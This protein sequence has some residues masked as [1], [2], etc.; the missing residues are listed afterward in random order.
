MSRPV[1]YCAITNHGFGHAVRMASVASAVQKLNPDILLILV[2]TAP[3]WLLDSYIEGDFIYRPRAFDVGVIQGDSITMDLEAT[4]K[5][6]DD[7]R[8]REKQIV[9][10]EVE[11]CNLN[12]VSLILGDV[13]AM[14]TQIA[15][16]ANI[17]CWLMSNFGWDFIYEPWGEDFKTIVSW[18]RSN[19][20]KCDRTFR[21][22]MYEEM[23]SFPNQT[24]VG[25][26]GGNPRYPE[27]ELR[28]KFVLNQPK[29]KTILLTF[30][31]LGLQA[32]P[33]E[34]LNLFPHWQFISFDQKAPD[35]PNLIK[36][37]DK[38]FRPVDFM[39]LCGKIISKPG[40][41][42]FAEAMRLDIPL[43]IL[44]R[45]GFAETPLL[46]E[47]LQKYSYHQILENEQFFESDWKF[48]K[49]DLKPPS[50][51]AKI[52]KNGTEV[53]AQEIIKKLT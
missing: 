8:R 19:Y 50:S 28:E 33:Y 37:T 20:S 18:L 15:Q 40:F 44:D 38:Y 42:T 4:L 35:L 29:E 1:L 3:R 30:G 36:I 16:R 24:D 31:G 53:I 21:L 26:T 48:L 5:K 41:S 2:T 17:P 7:F 9:T 47:G 52:V 14:V 27:T 22:P 23:G 6:M 51:K 13:P 32:I 25:L 11:F 10:G 43:I 34:N 45:K 12:R 46:I 49:E 39:P